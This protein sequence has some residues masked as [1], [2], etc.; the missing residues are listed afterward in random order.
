MHSKQ[1]RVNE[2][3][4]FKAQYSEYGATYS[5][6][7]GGLVMAK[8]LETALSLCLRTYTDTKEEDWIVYEVTDT[9]EEQVD[10]SMFA[11]W[12]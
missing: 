10:I 9:T 6:E 4:V 11:T 1:K 7:G 5:K 12:K 2:M 8:D 3:K